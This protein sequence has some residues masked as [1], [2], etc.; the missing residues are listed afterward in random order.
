M[1]GIKL[2]VTVAD[3]EVQAAFAELGRRGR[4]LAPV[5]ERVAAHYESSTRLRF[6]DQVAPDGMPW[7]PSQRA[8]RESG[9]TLY[10]QGLLLGSISS[11]G[12]ADRAEIGFAKVYAAIH[13][14]GGEAGRGRK[15]KLPAR[16]FLGSSA[17]DDAEVIAILQDFL[18]EVPGV[19]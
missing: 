5:M 11:R 9:K 13:Q 6:E 14:F 7:L 12:F 19:A 16:P 4:D 8:I 1:A 2:T 10:D 17:D 18:A 3:A 15:V